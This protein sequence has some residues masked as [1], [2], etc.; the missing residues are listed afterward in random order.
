MTEQNTD[1]KTQP[2][3][4]PSIRSRVS[5]RTLVKGA[6][7]T[8]AAVAASTRYH[9]P[10]IARQAKTPVVFWTQSTAESLTA[11]QKL[12]DAFNAQSQDTEVTLTQIPP[13]EVTDSAKLITAVR[14]GTGPD[15]YYLDRFIVSERAA[16][17]LLQ[18]LTPLM[19]AAGDNPDLK[20]SHIEFTANEA[21]WDGKPYALPFDTDVRALYYNKQLLQAGGVDPAEFDAANG[22]MLWD[23]VKEIAVSLNKTD[24]NGNF[25]QMGFVPWL[26]QGQHYTYGFSWGGNFFNQESCEVTPDDEKVV[27]AGNWIYNFAAEVGPEPIQAFIQAS[28]RPGAPP[29]DSPFVQKRLAMM[30]TGDWYI[31]TMAQYVPDVD[32]GITFIPVPSEG[33]ESTTWAGGWSTVIPQGA[34]EPEAAYRFMSY[35]CGPEGQRTYAVDTAHVPTLT[36][37]QADKSIFDERHLFFVNELLP[38][39]RN[40]PPL[41]VGAKYWDELEDAWDKIYLNQ[42]EAQPALETAKNNTQGELGQFCPIG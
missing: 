17:G 19:E 23:R 32:Y 18:D 42:E 7:G 25:T 11:Q 30:L 34:K 37:L 35:F 2:I 31:A 20:A 9:V 21:M 3:E 15:A 10:M 22:P 24:A 1:T 38:T 41:P 36:E 28:E 6:L 29:T 5:R 33:M 26:N 12:V 27:E 39:T 16:G 14:G 40:R 4:T 8:G 13:G